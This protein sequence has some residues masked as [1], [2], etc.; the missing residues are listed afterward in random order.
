MPLNFVGRPV[1]DAEQHDLHLY[2]A[3]PQLPHGGGGD[4]GAYDAVMRQADVAAKWLIRS[5]VVDSQE[6]ETDGA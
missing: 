2:R 5:W 3:T 1:G 6:Q 4:A